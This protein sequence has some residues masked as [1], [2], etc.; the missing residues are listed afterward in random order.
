ME[1]TC[2]VLIVGGGLVGSSLACALEGLGLAVMLAEASPPLAA[3]PPS[4]DER[5]LALA[6]ASVNALNG[7]GVWPHLVSPPAP[8][9]HI[10]V[11]SQG[12]FG[13]VRLDSHARGL[14]SFG[15]VVVARELGAALESR[16]DELHDLQRLRPARV[17]ALSSDDDGIDATLQTSDGEQQL[18]A[19]LLVAAD[20]TGSSLRDVLGIAADV[21]DYSQTLFVS[22][23][24][25]SKAPPDTA[26]ERFT[27]DG[28]VALLP[29]GA[30]RLGT[31]CTVPSEQADAVAALDED[32]YLDFLQQ[33]FGWRVGRFLRTGKRSAYPLR[34]LVAERLYAQRAVLV[35]NA[36]QTLHPIGAQGF[37]LGLRDALTLAETI[38]DAHRQGQDI[39]ALDVLEEHVRRRLPD[40]DATLKMSHGLVQFFSNTSTPVRLLRSAGMLAMDRIP[41]LANG[42]VYE[43]MGFGSDVSQLAREKS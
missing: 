25:A 4:F 32:G 16:L 37:N 3:K 6:R 38:G 18:R 5:N 8:I 33:R 13:S 20:G 22:V 15:A 19:R 41:G 11:S 26:Y 29:L 36:A 28:P 34:K 14:D 7:L 27:S 2:D 39:G 42:L 17:T 30:G 23:A 31:V 21:H 24:T 10:H 1:T 40:R 43:S 12:D 35:G 9:R